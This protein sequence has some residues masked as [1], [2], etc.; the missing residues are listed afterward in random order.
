MGDIVFE[1]PGMAIATHEVEGV[2]PYGIHPSFSGKGL[3]NGVVTDIEYHQE[4][5]QSMQQV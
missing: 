4:C 5:T 3:V 1:V 2:S